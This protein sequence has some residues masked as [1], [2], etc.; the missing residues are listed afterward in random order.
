M[1]NRGH[2]II[3]R[4]PQQ[5]ALAIGLIAKAPADYVVTVSEMTRTGEQ[6]SKLWAM[7]SDVSRAKPEGRRHTPEDWKALFMHACG[8]E[9]QF[10]PGLDGRPFPQGHRSS[11]LTK[12]QMSALIEF[13]YAY[14]SQ[15]GV[16]WSD[17]PQRNAA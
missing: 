10:L 2:T 5:R 15:H 1:S 12:S 11:R 9:C 4:G 6:N 13:I 14:G 17:E 3:L 7:L 8:W 16:Q